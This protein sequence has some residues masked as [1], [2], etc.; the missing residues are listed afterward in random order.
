MGG[1]GGP[2]S[3]D[4]EDDEDDNGENNTHN[5]HQ[6]ANGNGRAP[7]NG[8]GESFAEESAAWGSTR[9]RGMDSS[10]VIRL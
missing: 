9:P 8:T 1:R 10:G 3:L 4:D 5:H 6:Q 2:F 7:I